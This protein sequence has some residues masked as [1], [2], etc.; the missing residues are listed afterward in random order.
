M[1][2]RRKVVLRMVKMMLVVGEVEENS[3]VDCEVDSDGGDNKD[4]CEVDDDE[5]KSDEV[6]DTDD[7]IKMVMR[8]VIILKMLVWLMMVK[9]RIIEKLGDEDSE[10]CA[11]VDDEEYIYIYIKKE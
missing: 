7:G 6:D 4:G 8:M 3:A 10:E 5:D 2:M 11:V 1:V 9:M